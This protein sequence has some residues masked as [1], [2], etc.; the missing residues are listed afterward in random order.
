MFK[1][2]IEVS[3]Y[4]HLLYRYNFDFLRFQNFYYFKYLRETDLRYSFHYFAHW[5]CRIYQSNELCQ[6]KITILMKYI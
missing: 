5:V 3:E 4:S 2:L 1:I 6:S